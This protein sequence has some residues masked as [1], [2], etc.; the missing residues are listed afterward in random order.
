MTA[1]AAGIAAALAMPAGAQVSPQPNALPSLPGAPATPADGLSLTGSAEVLYNSNLLRLPSDVA[2]RFSEHRD[3][4]RYSPSLSATYGRSTGLIAVAV[5]G[6]IGRDFFQYNHY[7]DRNQYLGGGSLTYHSGS[8]CQLSVSG[9]YASRQA[10]IQSGS[11]VVDSTGAPVEDVG[12]VIDNVLT[13]STYGANAGCGSPTGR[14]T[15]GAGYLHSTRSNGAVTRRFG[16]SDADTFSGNVGLGILRPGQ[17]SLNGSYTTIVYPDRGALAA[18]EGLPP[19]LANVGVKIARIGLSFSRPIGTKL[20]GSIGVSFLHS[21]PGG[22]QAAYNSP[23]YTLALNYTSSSQLTFSLIGSRDIVPS[24]TAGALFRVADMI[25]LTA[26]YQLGQAI[27]ISPNAGFIGNTYKQPF[28]IVGEPA[29]R[30]DSTKSFGLQI[31][32]APRQLY[33]VTLNVQHY[34]RNSNPTT[35]SYTGTTAG[36]TLAVHL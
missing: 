10:G 36:L 18:L 21:D 23:A 8:S 15:F 3:D 35:Y 17:L 11:S 34:I 16:N 1:V 9:N 30:S 31:A 32:F 19:A 6:L 25:A 29:R 22:G 14:L 33:D 27:T 13:N 24:T 2:P 26:H 7:L 20:N 12:E 4:F 28:A 5:N